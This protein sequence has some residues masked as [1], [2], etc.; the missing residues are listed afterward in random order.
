MA[1][2]SI[3]SWIPANGRIS[4]RSLRKSRR[5]AAE[6]ADFFR[7]NQSGR[8]AAAGEAGL[9]KQESRNE[10]AL[11]IAASLLSFS[12]LPAFVIQPSESRRVKGAWWP[13]RSSKSPSV[14]TGR[15][16]FDSYP[17]RLF[18][19]EDQSGKQ[20]RKALRIAAGKPSLFFLPSCFNFFP[21][22]KE[23]ISMSREQIRKLTSLSS[24]AG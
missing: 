16:R 10:K 1:N 23:V 20:K 24:C 12:C 5:C 8:N 19:A 4:M 22:R 7:R 13:S 17:L 15:G 6:S 9:S 2:R 3:P 11:R 21:D 18:S 14:F